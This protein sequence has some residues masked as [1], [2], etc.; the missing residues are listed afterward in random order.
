L[1]PQQQQQGQGQ[2]EQQ[3]REEQQQGQGQQQAL[4]LLGRRRSLV[5]CEMPDSQLELVR[6]WL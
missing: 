5:D 3:E 6:A 1:P 2:Q 4:W